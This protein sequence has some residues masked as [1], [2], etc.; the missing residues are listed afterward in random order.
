MVVLMSSRKVNSC[1]EASPSVM[2]CKLVSNVHADYDAIGLYLLSLLL[3]ECLT[4]S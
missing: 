2:P 4:R 3:R 1:L